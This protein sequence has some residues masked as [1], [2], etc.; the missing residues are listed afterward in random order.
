MPTG[1]L[2]EKVES[3]KPSET[4]RV[5]PRASV[6]THLE[7]QKQVLVQDLLK[8]R[9]K[10][11]VAYLLQLILVLFGIVGVSLVSLVGFFVLASHLRDTVSA[12]SLS[13]IEALTSGAATVL[14]V[15]VAPLLNR[16]ERLGN[17]WQLQ[18]ERFTR[19]LSLVR[20]ARKMEA[21]MKVLA[22]LNCRGVDSTKPASAR[23]EQKA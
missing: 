13:I 5:R 20:I 7:K 23:L 6:Q 15:Q 19:L 10:M 22:A 2:V 21:L 17:A 1:A 11:R 12:E 14:G 16:L 18:E 8:N 3:G 9:R 4:P